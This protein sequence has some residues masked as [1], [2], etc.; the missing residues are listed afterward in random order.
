MEQEEKKSNRGGKRTGSGRPKT[1]PY[2][3]IVFRIDEAKKAMLQA[4]YG[5]KMNAMFKDWVEV[6]L[7]DTQL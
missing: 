2:T 1:E 4:K 3:N 6:L 7:S 5:K